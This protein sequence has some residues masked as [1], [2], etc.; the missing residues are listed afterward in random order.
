MRYLDKIVSVYWNCKDTKGVDA[1]I[2]AFLQSVKHKETVEKI[3]QADSKEER[4][5][6]KETLPAITISGRFSE[7]ASN[8]LIEHSGLICIDVDGSDNPHITDWEYFK[9]LVAKFSEVLYCSLS[10]SGNGVFCIVPIK[11]PSKHKEHYKAFAQYFKRYD[12]FVDEKCSNTDRLRYYSYDASPYINENAK[13]YTRLYNEPIREYKTGINHT[14]SED[15]LPL[16]ICVEKCEKQGIDITSDEGDWYKIASALASEMG[17][18]GRSYFHRLSALYPNY[19]QSETDSKYDYCLRHG[20]T[21]FEW[22]FTH[23]GDYGI[24]YADEVKERR[25]SEQR[26]I[27]QPPKVLTQKEKDLQAMEQLN[28]ALTEL[29][30]TFD[31]TLV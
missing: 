24:T 30:K 11:Y 25:R 22:L 15:Y 20:K 26:E 8:K 14:F 7:R 3:R 16:E 6:L 17:E 4:T 31:L 27:E 13:V 21:A 28:P 1:S 18:S 5:K 23:F 12:I 10:V 19:K 29:I 2:R 9:K